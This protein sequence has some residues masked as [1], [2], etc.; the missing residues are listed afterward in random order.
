MFERYTE[1]AR[2]AIF[3]AR[4]DASQYG[5]YY[6]DTEHLLLGLMRE[7]FPLLSNMMGSGISAHAIQQEIEK[8]IQRRERFSTAVE[9]PL[10]VE[11]KRVLNFAAE[12]AE[13][14]GQRHVGTEHLL[15]GLLREED[16]LAAVTLRRHGAHLAEIRLKLAG[17]ASRYREPTTP[18]GTHYSYPL[19]SKPASAM[20]AVSSFLSGLKSKTSPDLADFFADN[21]QFIDASGKIWFGREEI[22]K[23]FERL[24]AAFSKKNT[25]YR[26]EKTVSERQAAVLVSVLWENAVHTEQTPRSVIRMTILLLPEDEEWAIFLIQIAPVA[27]SLA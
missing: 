15:L 10:S 16:A 27:R 22:K 20:D 17:N 7:N 3:F 26:I 5:S 2:R 11:S 13:R 24:F 18:A 8:Q 9:V 23:E 19:A 6:I 14:L 1:K 21:G 4:Y 12:E 25:S